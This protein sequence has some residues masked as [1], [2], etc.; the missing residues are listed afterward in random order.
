MMDTTSEDRAWPLR[1]NAPLTN[2]CTDTWPSPS[3][4][5]EKSNFVDAGSNSNVA[6]YVD[7]VSSCNNSSNSAQVTKPSPEV[8]AAVKTS[9]N[10]SAYRAFSFILSWITCSASCAAMLIVSFMKRAVMI[11]NMA[12]RTPA[13]YTTKKS[14]QATLT[15]STNGRAY[16]CQPPPNVI[17]NVVHSDLDGVPK[18]RKK[19]TLKSFGMSS[20]RNIRLTDWHITKAAMSMTML[21]NTRDQKRA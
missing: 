20:S 19:S 10:F 11:R 13:M 5:M 1:R 15:S 16:F 21:S 18:Y 17:S 8:S 7:A 4:S 12:K 3:S 9:S 14:A 2:S 6:R